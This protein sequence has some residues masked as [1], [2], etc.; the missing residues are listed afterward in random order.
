MTLIKTLQALLL[1]SA[2]WSAVPAFAHLELP[3]QTM[4]YEPAVVELTGTIETQTFPG[5][6]NWESIAHGDEIER[7]WYLRL[8]QSIDVVPRADSN[9]ANIEHEGRVRIVQVAVGN[10]NI[11]K[12]LSAGRRCKLRGTLFHRLT[13]HHHARVLI[14][15]EVF[16]PAAG[17]DKQ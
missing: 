7:G 12:E 4:A 10:D 16:I 14:Y 6:P 8:D 2:G 13:G 5:P 1:F 3:R 9:S 15:A 17:G 11:W